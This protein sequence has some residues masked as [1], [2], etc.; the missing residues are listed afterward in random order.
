[1]PSKLFCHCS[2]PDCD[3]LYTSLLEVLPIHHVWIG[4]SVRLEFGNNDVTTYCLK[5]Y[6]LRKS[7][8]KHCVVDDG[9]GSHSTK[10]NLYLRRHHYP[11]GLLEYKAKNNITQQS[12]LLLK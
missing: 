10:N 2:W 9:L 3:D 4:N 8:F 7:V 5:K 1:M 12:L 11:T 6:V